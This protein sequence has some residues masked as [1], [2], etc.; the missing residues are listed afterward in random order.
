LEK[1]VSGG[2]PTASSSSG[3]APVGTAD[4]LRA[5]VL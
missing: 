4:A 5:F 2:S 1:G 3:A